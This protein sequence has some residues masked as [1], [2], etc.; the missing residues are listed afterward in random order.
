MMRPRTGWPLLSLVLSAA[1]AVGAAPP[2]AEPPPRLALDAGALELSI[3]E[4]AP[5][6]DVYGAWGR[7]AGVAIQADRELEDQ[8]LPIDLGPAAAAELLESLRQ[9]YRHLHVVIR[10]AYE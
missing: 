8:R 5:V 3:P 2:A 10:V 4:P 9:A 7:L 6:L 1:A